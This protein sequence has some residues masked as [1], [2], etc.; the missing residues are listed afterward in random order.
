[1]TLAL[2]LLTFTAVSAQTSV[3][4]TPSQLTI[5]GTRGETE[6]RTLLLR[7]TDPITGLHVIPLDLS[8]ADGNAVLPADA[9]R[10]TLPTDEIAADTPLTFPVQVD[11]H[12]AP[13][14]KFSGE[15]L[16]DYHGGSLTVPMTVTV[17]VGW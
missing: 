6:T 17:K 3:T 11:L 9:I 14:G 10:V 15:L 7:A 8:R 2:G 5:A 1:M 16:I 4:A 12:G 13:S